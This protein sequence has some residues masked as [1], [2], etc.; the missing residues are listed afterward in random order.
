MP[1]IGKTTLTNNTKDTP[2]IINN[3]SA[4]EI[5]ENFDFIG[6]AKKYFEIILRMKFN[7]GKTGFEK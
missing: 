3:Y 6:R 4:F 2:E 1:D 5:G 7:H